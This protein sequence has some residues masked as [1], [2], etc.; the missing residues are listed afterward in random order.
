V[1]I[2]VQSLDPRGAGKA[3]VD[4]LREYERQTGRQY[5]V[6]PA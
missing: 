2:F 4:A 3:V 1:Q 6:S 5:V